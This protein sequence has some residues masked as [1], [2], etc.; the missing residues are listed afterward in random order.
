[1]RYTYP[2]PDEKSY[3]RTMETLQI[4][5]LKIKS[6]NDTLKWPLQVFGIVA[7]RDILDHKRNIIFQ[8]HRNN[9][10]IINHNVRTLNLHPF[11]YFH[12]PCLASWI[13]LCSPL[14]I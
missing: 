2:T 14:C 4:I 1:M 11:Y 9:C 13:Y 10:Q 12:S 6:I 7:A 3:I 8:R 5:S